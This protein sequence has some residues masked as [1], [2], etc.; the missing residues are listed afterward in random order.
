MLE[1]DRIDACLLGKV[2]VG[3]A[4]PWS[5]RVRLISKTAG[6]TPMSL[7]K[8]ELLENG[9]IDACLLGTV[10]IGQAYSWPS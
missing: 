10:G 5:S 8:G 3:Q 7:G 1:T 9:R 2:R 6:V 4:N